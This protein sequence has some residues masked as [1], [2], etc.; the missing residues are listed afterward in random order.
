MNGKFNLIR[1]ILFIYLANSLQL[2]FL[3]KKWKKKQNKRRKQKYFTILSLK[4]SRSNDLAEKSLIQRK[5]K[6]SQIY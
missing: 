1:L 4:K 5:N 2:K 6:R 3:F